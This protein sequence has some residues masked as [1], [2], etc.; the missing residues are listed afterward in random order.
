M[1]FLEY[2]GYWTLVRVALIFAWSSTEL[3][4][5]SF[6]A[7][8]MLEA[9]EQPLTVR[10]LEAFLLLPAVGNRP[11]VL[12]DALNR[13]ALVVIRRNDTQHLAC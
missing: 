9:R 5:S 13:V 12:R 8:L 10:T 4:T 3:L 7:L 6:M 1:A 11:P 2:L